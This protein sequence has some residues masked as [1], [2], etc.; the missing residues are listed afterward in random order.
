M[1]EIS[2]ELQALYEQNAGCLVNYCIN[3]HLSAIKYFDSR[4]D[5][6]QTMMLKIW[7]CL[8]RYDESKAKFSTFVVKLCENLICIQIRKLKSKKRKAVLVSTDS[9]IIEGLT[10]GELI[11][12]DYNIEEE[13]INK[14]YTDYIHSNIGQLAY[15]YY[16]DELNQNDISRILNTSQ[17]RISRLIKKDLIKLKIKIRNENKLNLH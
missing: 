17:S 7:Q 3:N 11:A 14:Y 6:F 1:E 4:E 13:L 15:A 5:M 2:K 9:E 12:D 16:I 10:L 8:P